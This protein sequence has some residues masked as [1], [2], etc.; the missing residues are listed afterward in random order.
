MRY[1]G[2]H[3]QAGSFMLEAL[4]G[5]LIFFMGILTMLA[6][7]ASSIAVQADSQYRIEASNLADQILGEINLAVRDATGAVNPVTLAGFAHRATGGTT[8]CRLAATDANANNDCCNFS[9]Q[10]S[11]DATVTNWVAAVS[12]N[13]A[14]RLPGSTAARQQIVVNTGANA[15][16][17]VAVTVCWQGANDLRPRFH[18]VIG[19]VN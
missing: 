1:R 17:Q 2:K 16:N 14:T 8:T 12:T 11:A 15:G 5:I 10:E 7:Q 3:T 6:L 19:Y 18:R 13:P 9:G 4:I